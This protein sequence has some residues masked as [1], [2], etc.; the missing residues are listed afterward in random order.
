M[1]V[2]SSTGVYIFDGTHWDHV[3]EIQWAYHSISLP[4]GRML[5]G[6]SQGLATLEPDELGGYRVDLLTPPESYFPGIDG[7]RTV[8]HTRGHF[9][10]LHG[11][12]LVEVDSDRNVQL[13]ELPNW[14]TT[15]F[16]IGDE[17]FV[18]GG[19][20]NLLNRW[21][22]QTGQLVDA[23]HFLDNSGVYEWVTDITPRA[24]GGV[25]MLTKEYSIIGF[26]GQST[27]RWGGLQSVENH[28]IRIAS[29]I[30]TSPNTLAIGTT[31]KGV[32][33][34]DEQG[35]SLLQ[36]SKEHGLDDASI[37]QLAVDSQKGLWVKTVNN[38]TRIP[39]NPATLLL[40]EH[41]GL[42]D[43][44][45]SVVKFRDRIYL[46]TSKGLYVSNSQATQMDELFQIV[47]DNE[48]V[49]DLAVY[50]DHMFIAGATSHVM[51]SDGAISALDAFGAANFH[52]PSDY[53]DV[54]LA[55]NFRGVGRFELR[56][57]KW[58][59]TS[60]LEGPT[61]EVFS[62]AESRGGQLFGSLG[63]APQLALIDLDESGG[64][65]QLMD[66]P[67]DESGM[68]RT[69][70]RIGDHIYVN[71]HPCLKW[72]PEARR[73]EPDPEM[74]YYVGGPPFGFEQVYGEDPE[75]AVVALNA[76][77][78][79]TVKRPAPPII[80]DI[81]SIG[82][83]LDTRAQ[84]IL[85]DDEGHLWAG[86][87]FGLIY[88]ADPYQADTETDIRPRL[89][90]LVSLNDGERLPI[91]RPD[92]NEPIV[93]GPNQN[94]LK[95]SVTYPSL[96]ASL[97]HQYQIH[98]EPFDRDWGP[99]NDVT[100]R[101][102]TNLD[103]GRY[104]IQVNASD[105]LGH[106]AY[107]NHY[108]FVIEAPWY[109]RPW[110]IASFTGALIVLVI[111]IVRYYNR[112]QIERSR[113][114]EQVVK[115]RTREVEEKNSELERQ[116]ERLEAQ[117][118]EL[119]VKTVELQ[120]TT[121][122]L[123]DTLHRLQ[124]MQ[125]Q[126][127]ETARTAGKAEIA[128]NVL[129]NVGNVLNSINVS[130]NVLSDKLSQSKVKRLARLATLLEANAQDIDDFLT[131]NPKG[132]NVP[133]Y[134]IQLSQA[135]QNEV[136]ELICEVNIMGQD[137]DHVKRIISAQQSH[138]KTQSL[139]QE[140]DLVETCETALTILGRDPNAQ[141]LEINSELPERLIV[142]N[143]KHRVLEIVL[144]LISNALDAIREQSPDLGVLTLSYQRDEANNRLSLMIQDNGIGIAPE[145]I[146]RLF[147]HGFTTKQL[148][149]GFGL[150][151]CANTARVL[152][153]YISIRSD[154]IGKG[155]TAILTL[156][157]AFE[158]NES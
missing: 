128:T 120:S 143:D 138:A 65:Y 45:L 136:S 130:L 80:R 100:Q 48:E 55:A 142:V 67:T 83:A 59:K 137:V 97:H 150:H 118:S 149:H 30:E 11:T 156:P 44:V 135:L 106:F 75:S 36:F 98:V 69:P 134:L 92:E 125:D 152:G 46:G 79:Q 103:P 15:C 86:G 116:A 42:N 109:Q 18:T 52:Q 28:Q 76:R 114:L 43:E 132:K 145:N 146:D 105:A 99:F 104:T 50:R 129:H 23:D 127:M 24:E 110:S 20:D 17:L 39:F 84:C 1:A 34:I 85:I 141:R 93:L 33:V 9:F 107:G 133:S 139:T 12:K 58:E 82:N 101:E 2:L 4:E 51:D 148:G 87:T 126:L 140:F 19:N 96:I 90:Q 6:C 151:S 16:S 27:W 25:W 22:W 95:I 26:D 61:V 57:G 38:I 88:S 111:A 122:S 62:I 21:D 7:L 70:V 47:I 71:G 117:N 153:G 158:G 123:S 74:D 10:G 131:K 112:V 13:H 32:I 154:G 73:F 121:K 144:N 5:V 91:F 108:H 113:Y 66:L 102:I 115:E 119:E 37:E 77:S 157:I 81:S 8:A 64:S 40:N 60:Q 56:N 3:S 29:V 41:H 53:P 14:A 155:A 31:S 49:R 94:S 124:D 78:S 72:D 63:S 147:S 68:W 89:H 35:E 54:M